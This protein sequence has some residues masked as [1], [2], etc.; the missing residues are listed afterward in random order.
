MTRRKKT[1]SLSRIH[2]VKTG[3]IKKL[4]REAGN[5]RQSGK[6]VTRKNK[7]VF[8]KFLEANP[9]AKEQLKADQQSKSRPSPKPENAQASSDVHDKSKARDRD[10]N[11]PQVN[12]PERD[13][14][15]ERDADLLSLLD[16]AK[17]DEDIY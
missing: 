1:R 7:S 17:R 5:D 9:E 14:K 2:K 3:S 10:Q 12:G 16:N 11:L 6:R 4:K 15:K 13:E 8:E